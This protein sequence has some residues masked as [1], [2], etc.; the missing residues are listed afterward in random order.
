MDARSAVVPFEPETAFAPIQ[1]I[2]GE[3]G[4]YKGALLWRHEVSSTCS[5]VGRA[6]VEDVAIP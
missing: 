2:G 4:W 5:L 3:R 6:C 1:R